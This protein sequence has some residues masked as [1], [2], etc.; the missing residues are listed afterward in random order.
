MFHSCERQNISNL[1]D[2]SYCS[3]I[4]P[5]KLQ[6][7]NNTF[8]YINKPNHFLI[9]SETIQTNNIRFLDPRQ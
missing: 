9:I 7:F 2:S 1:Q 3:V 6:S 8:K 4:L 5:F